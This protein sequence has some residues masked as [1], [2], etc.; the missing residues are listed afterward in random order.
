[1][2]SIDYKKI[3][4]YAE[5]HGLSVDAIAEDCNEVVI[6]LVWKPG[7]A[8]YHQIMVITDEDEV[9][10]LRNSET[11]YRDDAITLFTKTML[12]GAKLSEEN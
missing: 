11:L 9:E 3:D 1:M 7:Q 6:A 4:D 12:D 10:V 8:Y 2:N 5:T